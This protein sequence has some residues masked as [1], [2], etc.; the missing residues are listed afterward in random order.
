M[1]N[2]CLTVILLSALRKFLY[3]IN[4][5]VMH[6]IDDKLDLALYAVAGFFMFLS[7]IV[8][9]S[10]TEL[11]LYQRQKELAIENARILSDKVKEI[12][13]AVYNNFAEICNNSV[14]QA[15]K[16]NLKLLPVELNKELFDESNSKVA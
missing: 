7:E 4:A 15:S 16:Q 14:Q 2:F 6:A 1:I 12:F 11:A 3:Q 9:P 13:K 10:K 5:E 8:K